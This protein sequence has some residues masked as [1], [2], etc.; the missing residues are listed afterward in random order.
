MIRKLRDHY[1]SIDLFNEPLSEASVF[2]LR[3]D[4]SAATHYIRLSFRVM[5]L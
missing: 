5:K 3:V 4:I 2:Q 1:F